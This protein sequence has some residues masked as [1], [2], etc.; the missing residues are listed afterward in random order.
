MRAIYEK[1]NYNKELPVFINTSNDFDYPPH[2]HLDVE[3]I[4]V[5]EG[6]TKF[7]IN[8]M[9]YDISQGDLIICK[10]GDVHQYTNYSKDTCIHT[11]IIF[12]PD[13]IDLPGGW[14]ENEINVKN[15]ITKDEIISKDL[16]ERISELFIKL[17]IE[18]QEKNYEQRI[19]IKSILLE[20]TALVTRNFS[21]KTVQNK[22]KRQKDQTID[23][24]R[25][26]ISYIEEN[27]M[28]DLT[29]KD[30]A[31]R[32]NVSHF[33]FSRIFKNIFD[34]NFKQYLDEYRI[35]KVVVMLQENDSSISQVA[36]ECGFQSIR[37]FNRIYKKHKGTSPSGL[38][39]K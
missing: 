18:Y 24:M 10:S 11:K 19:M 38:M 28:R 1:R 25:D 22:S 34:K 37:T 27:Y 4:F 31:K 3:I 29:L 23:M 39:V 32:F 5:N 14:P 8:E 26:I 36:F 21:D 35:Y 13:Y 7:R 30:I 15:I 17:N 16:F 20:L 12:K 6:S 2:W 33:H 9:L